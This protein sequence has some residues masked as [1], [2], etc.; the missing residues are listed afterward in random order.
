[1]K[2]LI[3]DGYNVINK[4]PKLK[5]MTSGN[6]LG[7]REEI[8]ALAHEYK[9]KRGGIDKAYVVFD[10]KDSCHRKRVTRHATQIFSKTGQGDEKIVRLIKQLS[11]K[12]HVQVITDDNYIR[13]HARVYKSSIISC[14]EFM[15]FLDKKRKKSSPEAHPAKVAED[16]ASRINRELYKYWLGDRQ[17]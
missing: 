1:M 12:Y 2:A 7:A 17:T 9:R 11:P 13:N 6:L 15:A 4:I 10:G 14:S 5:K 3:V 16:K 8:T